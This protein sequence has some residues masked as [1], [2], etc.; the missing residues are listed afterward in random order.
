[1][2]QLKQSSKL[3]NASRADALTLLRTWI[4]QP[5]FPLVNVS[6]DG[7]AQQ[8]GTFYDWG[9]QTLADPFSPNISTGG[10]QATNSNTTVTSRT[11][12]DTAWYVPMSL[13]QG[14]M[15]AGSES[16]GSDSEW[17][18]LST[19][20]A[21]AV[22]LADSGSVNVGGAGYYRWVWGSGFGIASH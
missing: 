1:M 2:Q 16:A 6:P 19:E 10:V 3:F 12:S 4:D 13:G 11:T 14:T 21:V 7:S 8:Q 18:E 5:G 17:I 20:S 22:N 9:S 15:A